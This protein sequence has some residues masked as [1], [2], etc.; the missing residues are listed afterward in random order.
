M[1]KSITLLLCLLAALSLTACGGGSKDDAPIADPEPD[2]A[3]NPMTEYSSMEELEE[4]TSLYI[5]RLTS[6]GITDEQYFLIDN[7]EDYPIAEYDFRYNGNEFTLRGSFSQED[8]SG[9][10]YDDG[11]PVLDE[12]DDGYISM[13]VEMEGWGLARWYE[14][15][16][17][18]TLYC[19]GPNENGEFQYIYNEYLFL[20]ECDDY[21]GCVNFDHILAD[22]LESYESGT[23]DMPFSVSFISYCTPETIGYAFMD[24]DNDDV[25]EMVL[26]DL[27]ATGSDNTSPIYDIYVTNADAAETCF[28]GGERDYFYLGADD[29]IINHWAGSASD[30]GWTVYRLTANTL[31]DQDEDVPYW[32]EPHYQLL[33]DFL[34]Q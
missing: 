19:L 13:T 3:P 22:I 1:K 11:T 17:Q 8:I 7:G 25:P 5:T 30:S 16:A 32:Y 10:Y 23:F 24:L 20:F 14:N 6:T 29:V 34:Q 4:L 2:A 27:S 18:F 31:I 26:A 33:S 9:V 21:A 28:D 12:N 15:D